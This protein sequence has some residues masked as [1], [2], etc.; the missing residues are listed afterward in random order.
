MC[1]FQESATFIVTFLWIW[2]YNQKSPK[3]NN[4]KMLLIFVPIILILGQ[5]L[6][7]LL[8]VCNLFPYQGLAQA[9]TQMFHSQKKASKKTNVAFFH[10]CE[11]E[12]FEIANYLPILQNPSN[13]AALYV[14]THFLQIN[15]TFIVFVVFINV[16]EDYES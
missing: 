14:L 1:N 2:C 3:T 5:F 9:Y 13:I 11:N 12:I 15:A 10:Y 7:C 6:R 4:L 16:Y 8:L